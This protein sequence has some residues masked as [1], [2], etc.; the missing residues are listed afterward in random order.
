M[1]H[2]QYSGGGNQEYC[3]LKFD[4]LAD[5]SCGPAAQQSD[6]YE[7]VEAVRGVALSAAMAGALARRGLSVDDVSVYLASSNTPL[8]FSADSYMLGGNTLHVRR[9]E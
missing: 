3:T 1:L 8:P 9:G 7:I 2:F 4:L 5:G 6:M